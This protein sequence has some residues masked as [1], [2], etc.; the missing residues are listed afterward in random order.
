MSAT[1][2]LAGSVVAQGVGIAATRA[3]DGSRR[4]AWVAAAFAGMAVS[5]VLM[6]RAIAQ[7]LSLAVGYGIWSGSGIVLAATAGTVVFG[8]HLSRRHALGLALV[9]LG[10]V[11]VHGAAS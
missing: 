7:G 11:V 10:V 8:D 6:S 9:V 2:L 4:R 3:S 5:V 1:L